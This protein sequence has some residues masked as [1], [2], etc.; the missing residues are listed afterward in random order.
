MLNRLPPSNRP[1]DEVRAIDQYR[2]FCLLALGRTAEAEHAIEAVVS[3][4]RPISRPAKCR[5]ACAPRSATCASACCRRSSSRSTRTPRRRTI[6]REFARRRGR[7]LA[8]AR[9][10]GGPGR[11]CRR[12]PAAAG[13]PAHARRRLSRSERFRRPRRRRCR[14]PVAMAASPSRRRRR[15]RRHRCRRAIYATVDAN[16]MPPVA[17]GSGAAAIPGHAAC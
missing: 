5:R 16:V 6:G 12:Q 15:R 2:A 1:T 14:P 3:A 7:L 17:V 10:D 13:R 4:S 8:R 11:R 9:R